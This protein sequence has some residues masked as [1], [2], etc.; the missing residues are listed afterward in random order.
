[1]NP[2]T[3]SP[4]PRPLISLCMI[5]G[6]VEEYIDTCLTSFALIADEIIIVRAIGNQTPDRTCDIARD[7]FGAKIYEYKNAPGHEDWPHVDSF[8]AARQMSFDMSAGEFRFWCDSDDV[9]K[10]GADTIRALAEKGE[11]DV[12]IFP[13]EIFGRGVTV[14]RER[15]IRRTAKGSWLYPVHE[16]FAFDETTNGGTDEGVIVE[17]LPKPSKTGSNERNLRILEGVAQGDMTPGL[18][19]HLHQELRAVGRIDDSI[20]AATRAITHPDVGRPEKYELLLNLATMTKDRNTAQSYLTAAFAVNPQRREALGLMACCAI[21]AGRTADALAL[22]RQMIATPRPDDWSWNDRGAAYGWLGIDIFTQCL[23]ASGNGDEAERVRRAALADAGGARISLLHATRGRPHEASKARKMWL[24]LAEHPETIEHIFAID[25]DDDESFALRRFHH[26]LVPAGGGCVA[27]WNAAASIAA[28][29]IYIQ[30]SDDWIPP[31]KWDTLI[32]ERMGDVKQPRVLA[33]S[34]G[35]RTDS[36]LCMAICTREYFAQ[37]WFMFHPDFL[38]MYSDNWFTE[39]AHDRHAVIDARD[40]VF[41][42]DHPVFNEKKPMDRTYAESNAPE[43]YAQGKAVLD[44]L[45]SGKDWSRIPGWTRF[46]PTYRQLAATFLKDGDTVVEVGI[47]NGR[48]LALLAQE[49]ANHGRKVKLFGVDR[50]TRAASENFASFGLSAELI[51]GDS[52]ASASQFE[53][54]SCTLVFIDAAHD[55]ESVKRDV[56][57]WLP[58]IKAGGLIGGDDADSPEVASAVRELL[59][60]ATFNGSTWLYHVQTPVKPRP[61]L[62]IL[63]PAIWSRVGQASAL[64]HAI[65]NQTGQNAAAVYYEQV[66]HLTV[67]DNRARSVGLKRQA[68]L[69]SARGE[70]IAFVDDDDKISSDYVS[71]ILAAIEATHADV[72]TFDQRAVVNG[73]SAI[74]NF[75]LT[76]GDNPFTGIPQS[77]APNPQHLPRIKR[78]AWHVNVWKRELVKDCIFPDSSYGEDLVWSLQ[79][80]QRVKTHHHI[81][82]VLHEYHHS[83]ATTAAPPPLTS[84]V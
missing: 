24:D 69:D 44:R 15:M 61:L 26:I 79:A 64:E 16:C 11:H 76:N 35:H 56:S 45:R 23:R 36:L 83:T 75:D 13:Y 22:A 18:W 7:K 29:D 47:A 39:L 70:Y 33:I 6:N 4:N 54:A 3:Q 34:D 8:A 21:D 81:D 42:H 53:N 40:L 14:P 37:D 49:C 57:A 71:Q 58:K 78:G 63:T 17:H 59:P 67:F 52:A 50:N 46:W 66:E 72:I 51:T 41:T 38:S 25:E 30:L 55:Y 31:A 28:G 60:E 80:R 68:C 77:P 65:R 10:S 82:A 27:A 74:V 12:Y 2:Q 32:R 48:S 73:E 62:S 5:V 9:L 1:M 43:R 84:P 20:K 19:F